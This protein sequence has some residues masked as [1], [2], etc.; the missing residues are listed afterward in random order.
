MR[1]KRRITAMDAWAWQQIEAWL[2]ARQELPCGAITEAK[3]LIEDW[4]QKYNNYR[5]PSAPG[6]RTP[7]EYAIII[8][9]NNQTPQNTHNPGPLNGTPSA[10]SRRLAQDRVVKLGDLM[11]RAYPRKCVGVNYA[12]RSAR[13]SVL[14]IFQ[15]P[16]Y[17]LS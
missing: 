17:K 8:N 6:G 12:T 10:P 2:T 1:D 15:Y 14:A 16:Q 7:S 4:R 13:L 11:R 5:T 3:V 9:K